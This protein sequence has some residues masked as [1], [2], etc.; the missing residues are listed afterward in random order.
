MECVA[1]G[2]C[3]LASLKYFNMFESGWSH[4]TPQEIQYWQLAMV[5]NA[6]CICCTLAARQCASGARPR[7]QPDEFLESVAEMV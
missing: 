4:L 3:W 1:Y 2:G 7:S 6:V 5:S